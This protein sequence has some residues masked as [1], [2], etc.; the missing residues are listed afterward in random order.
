LADDDEA[1]RYRAYQRVT[2]LY[3]NLPH[4]LADAFASIDRQKRLAGIREIVRL[5]PEL[6]AAI[7]ARSPGWEALVGL[8]GEKEGDVTNASRKQADDPVAAT[9]SERPGS[10]IA[11]NK[12][13]QTVIA[14]ADTYADALK[15]AG[16]AGEADAEID[17]AP[18]VHPVAAAR[19]F[20]LLEDESQNI[21]ADVERIIPDAIEW[22]DTPNTNLW[23]ERPRDLIGTGRERQLRYLLRGIRNGI[24]T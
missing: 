7:A 3:P 6:K 10:W 15:Q 8:T 24:T 5:L 17:K 13:R 22:L 14:I 19:P 9:M 20:T 11:W 18:G 21:I 1:I 16:N 23:F 2:R 12:A 4:S